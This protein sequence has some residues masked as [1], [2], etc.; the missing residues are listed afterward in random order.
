MNE[1]QS[2]IS[3]QP[4][5][6]EKLVHR[7]NEMDITEQLN[8]LGDAIMPMAADTELARLQAERDALRKALVFYADPVSWMVWINHPEIKSGIAK[9][10]GKIAID[11]LDALAAALK[12][13]Q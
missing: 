8:W 10:N 7:C 4:S 2:A 6:L 3:G 5:A 9:D 13:S 1:K 11:A 12:E